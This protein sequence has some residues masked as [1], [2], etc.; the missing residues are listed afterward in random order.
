ME[1]RRR[2]ATQADDDD[3]D[4]NPPRS[5][6]QIECTT[7]VR[8]EQRTHILYKHRHFIKSYIIFHIDIARIVYNNILFGGCSCV[9]V[10]VVVAG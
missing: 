10:C 2:A 9:C 1:L 3:D 5:S 4:I 7:N 6:G 8:T